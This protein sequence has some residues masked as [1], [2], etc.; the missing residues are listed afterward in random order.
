M[1]KE[2][3]RA[4]I[5]TVFKISNSSLGPY[6]RKVATVKPISRE[7]NLG[8]YSLALKRKMQAELGLI[9]ILVGQAIQ[10]FRLPIRKIEVAQISTLEFQC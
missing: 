4:K 8:K 9:A 5:G 7:D 6:R 10:E 3:D 2:V 1:I